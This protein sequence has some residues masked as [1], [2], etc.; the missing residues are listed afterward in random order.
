MCNQT[1]VKLVQLTDA[2]KLTNRQ[3][4]QKMF[5]SEKCLKS[6]YYLSLLHIHQN[7]DVFKHPTDKNKTHM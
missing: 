7:T 6:V 4:E 3:N 2:L 5:S 1:N